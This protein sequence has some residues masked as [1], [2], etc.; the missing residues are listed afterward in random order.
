PVQYL[1]LLEEVLRRYPQNTIVWMHLGLSKEL[2]RLDPDTHIEIVSRLLDEHPNLHADIAWRV[3]YDQ[4]FGKPEARSRYVAFLNRY[5]ERIL[6]GTDFLALWRKDEAVYAEELRVTSDI[7]RDVDDRAFRA[8]AL[9]DNYF[10]LLG[11]DFTA[12][13]VCPRA[14]TP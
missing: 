8:I 3:L 7:L 6:P 11:L 10:R 14:G 1:P 9:G 4:Y 12:P 2:K 13:E 5:A